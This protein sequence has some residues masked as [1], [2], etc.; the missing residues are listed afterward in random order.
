[1]AV[2]QWLEP[3]FCSG[4]WL[5]RGG[6]GAM[7]TWWKGESDLGS[8]QAPQIRESSVELRDNLRALGQI[9]AQLMTRFPEA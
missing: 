7:L 1:M 8:V 6:R 3:R 5:I 4:I 9:S 2:T